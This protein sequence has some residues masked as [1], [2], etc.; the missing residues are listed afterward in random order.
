MKKNKLILFA[1]VL[2]GAAVFA[3]EE[4]GDKQCLVNISL[5]NESA[6]NKQYADAYTPWLAAYG[7]CPDANRAI[8]Q[9]GREILQWKFTQLKTAEEFNETLKLM[10]E[11]Y[12][13]RIQ[14][15]G[16]DPRYPTPWILG[17]K[18]LDYVTY[19]QDEKLKPTAYEWFVKS[20]DALGKESEIPVLTEFFKLSAAMYKADKETHGEKFITDYLKISDLLDKQA[21]D[22]ENKNAAFSAQWKQAIDYEFVQSGAAECTTLDEVYAK[23]VAE[24]LENLEYLNNVL[25]F[26]RMTGCTDQD[27]YFM[28]AE[29]AHKIEP[30]EGSALALAQMSYTKRK[31]YEEAINYYQQA[32]DLT[33]NNIDKADHQYKIAFV[34]YNDLKNYQRARDYA[35]N[36]L[37]FNPNRGD[38]YLL[39]G[40]MYAASKIYDDPVLAK[41][42]YWAAVDKFIQAKNADSDPENVA[43]ANR[44]IASYSQYFPSKEDIFFHPDLTDGGSFT[45]GGWIGETTRVREK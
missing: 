25:A 32:T 45:V 13:K 14:Y 43:S 28:A 24:N 2:C 36:A 34:Y 20:I 35:R 17:I 42:V 30:T 18:A 27:V 38:A 26:Y 4:D 15:F 33:E 22:P 7:E 41:S 44:Y 5:F 1:F 40:F 37:K 19:Q 23:K 6:K 11:M 21:N 8:Y 3:Q 16:E 10:M 9:R 12:D 39:I 29:A 31:N